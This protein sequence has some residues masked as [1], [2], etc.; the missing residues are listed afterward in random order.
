MPD[1]AADLGCENPFDPQENLEASA[2]YLKQMYDLYGDWDYAL[3]A[4]NGGPGNITAG[5]PLPSFAI[6][7]INGVKGQVVGSYV[8]H[9]SIT[10]EQ[11]SKYIRMCLA[12]L[13]LV[14]LTLR[15][16]K[17]IMQQIGGSIE[18]K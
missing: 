3:G 12:L 6:E 13:G 4:Y 17:T 2:K 7:Y 15:V 16:P 18:I 11:L 5:Q 1:T 10:S 9:N 8:A 14:W